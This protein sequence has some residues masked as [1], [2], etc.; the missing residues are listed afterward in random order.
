MY[1]YFFYLKKIIFLKR[2]NQI[3]FF[4]FNLVYSAINYL[5]IAKLY[6]MAPN[7]LFP[8]Y[9]YNPSPTS[10]QNT[11]YLSHLSYKFRYVSNAQTQRRRVTPSSG[12]VC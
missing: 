4:F 1:L 11:N 6:N 7:N 9:L 2:N 3:A 8:Q 10:N 5:F 12:E